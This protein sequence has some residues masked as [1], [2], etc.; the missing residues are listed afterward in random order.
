MCGTRKIGCPV[1]RLQNKR[2]WGRI[3]PRRQMQRGAETGWPGED[4]SAAMYALFPLLRMEADKK[5]YCERM[6]SGEIIFLANYRKAF[7]AGRALPG[8]RA[9]L[10]RTFPGSHEIFR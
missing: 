6:N 4:R 2:G 7:P 8:L 5:L 10:S 1:D 9:T 3:I